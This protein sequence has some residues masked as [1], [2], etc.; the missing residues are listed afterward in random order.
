VFDR[1][2]NTFGSRSFV[3][4]DLFILKRCSDFREHQNFTSHLLGR[5]FFIKTDHKNLVHLLSSTVPKVIRWQL[6]LLEFSFIVIHLPGV[7][8]VVADT[9]SRSFFHRAGDGTSSLSE[10]EKFSRFQSFH[11]DI[12]GHHGVQ[13]TMD[14]MTAAGMTWPGCKKEISEY[15]G[16]CLIC[17]KFKYSNITISHESRY[18]IHGSHPMESLSVDT[19]GPLPE[20]KLGN[21][22]ILGIIDN[23]TKFITLFPTQSTTAME[24]V[25]SIVKHIGLFGIPKT[26]RTDGGTQFTAKVCEELSK[27]LQLKHLV[28][29]PYH[30]EANGVIE[31]RNAEVMKHLRVL[32]LG[33][34]VSDSWSQ[35][36]P[37]VQRILNFTKDTSIDISPSR[38]LFG[39][40]LSTN[41]SIIV[42]SADNRMVVSEY[43]KVLQAQQLSLIQTSR[44]YVEKRHRKHD[45]KIDVSVRPNYDEGDYVLLSYPSRPPS[46]LSGLYRGP[47]VIHRRIRDDIYEVMDLITEKIYQVHISRIK[48]LNL[49]PNIDRLELLRLA[50]ID[51][52]E[53]VVESIINHRGNARDKRNLEFLV[54]W[55]GYEPNDDSWE[56]YD[57]VK[58]LMALDDYSKTHPELNLG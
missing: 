11:N 1:C 41:P 31:R 52:K 9:L 8:N 42:S 46:K 5:S 43:L 55:K 50:G 29:I 33:R 54:R 28:V 45:E 27:L 47:L 32:V 38:L 17:Q 53:Y 58:D 22:Y 2:L 15:I 30:P 51:H 3:G 12:T 18:H 20:D 44:E 49:S 16:S 57:T 24:Y 19:I 26:I 7:D 56:P 48:A 25:M 35:V 6:R 37:L 23:F 13:K 39:D 14:I 21:K 10:D 4:I 36:L 34:D 40:M